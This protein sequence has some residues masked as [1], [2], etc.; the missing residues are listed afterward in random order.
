MINQLVKS[1]KWFLCLCQKKEFKS[2]KDGVEYVTRY[3]GRTPISENRIINYDG[4][5]V[6]FCYNAHEDNSYHEITVTAE[7]FILMILRHLIPEQYKIIRYY[8]FY[9]KKHKLHDKIVMLI[10]KVKHN[11]RKSLLKHEFSIIK[12]FNRLPY[13]C[14]KCLILIVSQ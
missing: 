2:L 11:A 8:G 3:C 10:D 12:S 7:E 9:R 1:Q 13:D 5:N 14:S 6:T 4:K